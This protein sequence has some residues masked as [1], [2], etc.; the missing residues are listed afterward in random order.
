MA[1]KL[2]FP[3]EITVNIKVIVIETTTTEMVPLL[4]Y[5]SI[6]LILVRT[7]QYDT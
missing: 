1:G 5:L 4:K 6:G 7:M 3:S 2:F